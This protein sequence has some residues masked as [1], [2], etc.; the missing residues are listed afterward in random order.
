MLLKIAG[1]YGFAPT[2]AKTKH[3]QIGHEEDITASSGEV[4]QVVEQAVYLG[5]LITACSSA[6]PSVSRRIG[7]ACRVFDKLNAVW[8]H[9]NLPKHRKVQL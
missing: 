5:S 1:Q 6:A 4:I 9:A 7:E 2:L 8:K 3:M